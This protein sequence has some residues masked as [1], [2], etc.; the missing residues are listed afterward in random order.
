MSENS[1]ILM[2]DKQGSHQDS[3]GQD[4][5]PILR[6]ESRIYGTELNLGKNSRMCLVRLKLSKWNEP[7]KMVAQLSTLLS[8]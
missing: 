2:I 5:N 7:S 6:R 8:S 1:Q 4:I 3:K